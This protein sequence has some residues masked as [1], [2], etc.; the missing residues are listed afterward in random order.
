MHRRNHHLK[1]PSQ[2]PYYKY[3]FMTTSNVINVEKTP[4]SSGAD[5]NVSNHQL[6]IS[7]LTRS[8]SGSLLNVSILAAAFPICTATPKRCLRFSVALFS[9]VA[10][11][12]RLPKSLTK[13]RV[14]RPSPPNDCNWQEEVCL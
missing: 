9:L 7:S 5:G 12:I 1:T 14:L 6:W 13:S 10:R 4:E 11:N 3:K 8:G 2:Y